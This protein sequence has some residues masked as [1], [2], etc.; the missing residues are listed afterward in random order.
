M[1]S[2]STPLRP[3]KP[4][5]ELRHT[6]GRGTQALK[7]VEGLIGGTSGHP[8]C[9]VHFLL[10][11]QQ[12]VFPVFPPFFCLPL[13]F[14]GNLVFGSLIG[15]LRHR[16]VLPRTPLFRQ[17]GWP[18]VPPINLYTSF[19]ARVPLSEVCRNSTLGFVGLYGVLRD[20]IV[21]LRGHFLS[22]LDHIIN[23]LIYFDLVSYTSEFY[24][25]SRVVTRLIH[26]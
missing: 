2:P 21:D 6:S 9:S 25:E 5:V 19:N 17:N 11:S 22:I 7:L 1:R 10:I 15:L 18:D 23:S 14:P 20:L 26:F 13:Y 4:N 8:F 12:P 16:L 3:T 24:A